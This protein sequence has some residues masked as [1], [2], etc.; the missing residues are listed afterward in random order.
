MISLRWFQLLL[1]ADILL[2]LLVRLFA[3]D[4]DLHL[5]WKTFAIAAGVVYAGVGVA[6]KIHTVAAAG[7]PLPIRIVAFLYYAALFSLPFVTYAFLL[8]TPIVFALTG[9]VWLCLGVEAGA[10][11]M[12]FVGP[13]IVQFPVA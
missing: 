2:S 3:P 5:G 10:L 6:F 12:A 13:Y 4:L 8:G 11:A 9:N 7:S 1:L